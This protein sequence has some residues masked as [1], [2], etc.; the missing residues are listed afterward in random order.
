MAQEDSPLFTQT[1][2][3]TKL[4]GGSSGV[5]DNPDISILEAFPNR[6]PGR[7]YRISFDYP[8][9]TSLCPVTGQPDFGLIRLRYVPDALCLEAKSFKL[10]LGAFRNRGAFME[11][12]V[13]A[14][15]DDFVALLAPRRLT[16]EGVFN[17]R[18]G[19]A[20]SVLVD[21][22]APDLPPERKEALAGLW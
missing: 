17:V 5:Y 21:H 1:A 4:G 15:A 22:L 13:N 14:I 6:H 18:G 10:Y 9:F 7:D 20:I 16:L 3:L 8:E 11:N 12:I 19:T 2:G